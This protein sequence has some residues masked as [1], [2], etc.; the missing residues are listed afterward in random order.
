MVRS[1]ENIALV[2]LLVFIV[3]SAKREIDEFLYDNL[4]ASKET[5]S[6]QMMQRIK[7][8]HIESLQNSLLGNYWEKM[9]KHWAVPPTRT[10]KPH[11]RASSTLQRQIH[12]TN[13][14][15][16]KMPG[17]EHQDANALGQR[18]SLNASS[19]LQGQTHDTFDKVANPAQGQSPMHAPSALERQ[20]NGTLDKLPIDKNQ[21]VQIQEHPVYASS[22]LQRQIDDTADKMTMDKRGARANRVAQHFST[23]ASHW[24]QQTPLY[25]IVTGR[26]ASHFQGSSGHVRLNVDSSNASIPEHA[27]GS[28]GEKQEGSG[29]RLPPLVQL[30]YSLFESDNASESTNS[31]D[32]ARAPISNGAMNATFSTDVSEP[33]VMQDVTAMDPRLTATMKPKPINGDVSS[34]LEIAGAMSAKATSH[35][36]M[37][38][39]G[40]ALIC[41]A[42]LVNQFA[43]IGLAALVLWLTKKYSL[44]P[45][46]WAMHEEVV[47]SNRQ[48]QKGEASLDSKN[49]KPKKKTLSAYDFGTPH[50]VRQD[51]VQDTDCFQRRLDEV[52]QNHG[53][54]VPSSLPRNCEPTH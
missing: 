26:T 48:S 49:T 21:A 12:D 33:V 4:Y 32:V 17:D 28:V 30:L 52:L 3:A 47:D 37:L 43:L 15:F 13:S 19:V 25:R 11:V 16:E 7:A 44:W 38:R 14:T 5:H 54:V 24:Y 29:L 45:K 35:M 42:L 9:D 31:S 10:Q 2:I 40:F 46:L 39:E 41:L 53:I 18:P 34:V 22:A 36:E 51:F 23:S 8:H 50:D 20:I 27:S 6:Q 1:F